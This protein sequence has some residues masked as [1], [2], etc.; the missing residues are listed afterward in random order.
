MA[1][2]D[3]DQATNLCCDDIVTA[4]NK[5]YNMMYH[6]SKE[7]YETKVIIP[8]RIETIDNWT[9]VMIKCVDGATDERLAPRL[10]GYDPGLM[11]VY[12]D[13]EVRD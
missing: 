12:V 7:L 4:G 11:R 10:C 13:R 1:L 8:F 6:Y 3:N 2:G 5:F 9:D